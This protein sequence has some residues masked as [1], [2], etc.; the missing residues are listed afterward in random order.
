MPD[1]FANRLR[2]NQ[3]D[4]EKLLWFALRNRQIDKLKFRRQVPLGPYIADF[5]CLENKLIVEL[6]G[7]QHADAVK[8][9]EA[10]T[11]WLEGDGFHVIRFWNND[12]LSNREGVLMRL[13]E[14]CE[15][16]RTS[17]NDKVPSPLAGEG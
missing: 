1:T 14:K 9:D 10:R 17:A 6:D 11:R 13:M 12:V 8:Y 4:A 7:G 15:E 16:L 5:V 2:I 3:T